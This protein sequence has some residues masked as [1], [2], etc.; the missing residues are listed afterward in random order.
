MSET[1]GP[2]FPFLSRSG[3]DLYASVP[4]ISHPRFFQPRLPLKSP[5]YETHIVNANFFSV[6]AIYNG[7]KSVVSF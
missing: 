6:L 1:L 2:K 4:F 3:R 5:V 7:P